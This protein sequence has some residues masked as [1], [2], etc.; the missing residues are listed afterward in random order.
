MYCQ[1]E[2]D[3]EALKA[4]ETFKQENKEKEEHAAISTY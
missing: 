2:E 3:R 1:D 4:L